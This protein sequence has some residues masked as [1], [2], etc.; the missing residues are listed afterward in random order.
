MPKAQRNHLAVLVQKLISNEP[1]RKILTKLHMRPYIP[2]L[3]NG[4]LE[5]DPDR[6]SQFCKQFDRMCEDN[7]TFLD[8]IVWTDEATFKLLGHINRHNCVY[9]SET[10]F[11]FTI[12][13]QLSQPGITV[14]AGISFDGIVGPQ[15]FD[16][17]VTGERYLDKL[18]N[19]IVPALKQ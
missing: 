11:H 2:R 8:K 15:F 12:T 17:T 5:D 18:R 1:L 14:W 16:R 7:P 9:W 13:S 10:N 3:I 19:V 4:L 6:R